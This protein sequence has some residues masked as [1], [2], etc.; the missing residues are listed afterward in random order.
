[1]PIHCAAILFLN[2]LCFCVLCSSNRSTANLSRSFF[3]WRRLSSAALA[4]LFDPDPATRP[5]SALLWVW[6]VADDLLSGLEERRPSCRSHF[7]LRPCS[8]RASFST[9]FVDSVSRWA[10]LGVI[11]SRRDCCASRN[12]GSGRSSKCYSSNQCQTP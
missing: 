10:M 6:R 7:A 4:A 2:C 8:R 3:C 9:W 11:S 5:R 12:V 1:M